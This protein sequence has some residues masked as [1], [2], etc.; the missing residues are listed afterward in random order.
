MPHPLETLA[1]ALSDADQLIANATSQISGLI[2]AIGRD[3]DNPGIQR[4]PGAVNGY[5][6]SLSTLKSAKNAKPP[7]GGP[8]SASTFR[9]DPFF[10][11]WRA[12]YTMVKE[13]VESRRF[14]AVKDLLEGKKIEHE[15]RGRVDLAPEVIEN[16]SN[17]I[18]N[19]GSTTATPSA[20]AS[21]P[22]RR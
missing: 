10:H 6:T 9:M 2:D 11:D 20:T 18:G 12:Q 8:S 1:Q 19:L 5:V 22:R 14:G 17:V 21:K 13:L 4:F 7:S 16:L 15:A 3:R